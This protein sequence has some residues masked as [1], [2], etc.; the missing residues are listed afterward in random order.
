MGFYPI[1]D[2]IEGIRIYSFKD[3]ISYTIIEKHYNSNITQE[4]IKEILLLYDQIEDKSD[5]HFSIYTLCY[6]TLD[7]KEYMSWY[8]IT[9]D[10]LKEKLG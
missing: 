1:Y 5:L 2:Y 8:P 3:D 9:I 7:N 6:S 4:Q 10:L